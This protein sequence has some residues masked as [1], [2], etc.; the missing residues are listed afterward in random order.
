MFNSLTVTVDTD[1]RVDSES[2]T[3]CPESPMGPGGLPSRGDGQPPVAGLAQWAQGGSTGSPSHASG[4]GHS[5]SVATSHRDRW[6]LPGKLSE[7]RAP[8][9]HSMTSGKFTELRPCQ[10]T[11]RGPNLNIEMETR[12]PGPAQTLPVARNLSQRC[13][14]IQLQVLLLNR[15]TDGP[16]P[17]LES[18][19]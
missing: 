13:Q 9:R 14:R 7:A 12:M 6:T 10:V 18:E 3:G 11:D 1:G 16:T 15:P 8:A 4:P 17:S 2:V 19:F 5:V